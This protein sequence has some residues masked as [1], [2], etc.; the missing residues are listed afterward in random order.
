[1]LLGA[2][3]ITRPFLLLPEVRGAFL[4][5]GGR[6]SRSVCSITAVFNGP[7]MVIQLVLEPFNNSRHL[8]FGT[9]RLLLSD[10]RLAEL[11]LLGS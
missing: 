10:S 11:L 3:D 5:R 7:Y 1:M 6:E 4:Q 9:R 2:R 8:L